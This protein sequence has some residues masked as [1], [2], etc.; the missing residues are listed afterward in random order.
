MFK[1][2]PAWADYAEATSSSFTKVKAYWSASSNGGGALCDA[3]VL[4]DNTS[5]KLKLARLG[6]YGDYIK[7]PKGITTYLFEDKSVKTNFTAL[8]RATRTYGFY[9]ITRL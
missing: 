2:E 8:I 1:T 9:H 4:P 5:L 3:S 7:D 6:E